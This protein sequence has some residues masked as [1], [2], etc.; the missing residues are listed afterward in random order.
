RC[1]DVAIA[2]RRPPQAVDHQAKDESAGQRHARDLQAAGAPAGQSQLRIGLEFGWRDALIC[3]LHAALPYRL[4]A[5]N[6]RRD[7]LCG[8]AL[9][10]PVALLSNPLVW[11]RGASAMGR[12]GVILL[13]GTAI[14]C[15][16]L[17]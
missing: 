9:A 4:A 16:A 1:H 2:G 6:Q 14:L 17:P 15:G 11:N 3:P 8:S 7:S 12:T 13:T 10:A 5:A